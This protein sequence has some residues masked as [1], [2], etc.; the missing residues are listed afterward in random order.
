MSTSYN[1]SEPKFFTYKCTKA[2][3]RITRTSVATMP[4][5]GQHSFSMRFYRRQLKRR[6][7]KGRIFNSAMPETEFLIQC[8][9]FLKYPLN[10]NPNFSWGNPVMM[11]GYTKKS[12]GSNVVKV[13]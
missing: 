7:R 10:D 13:K 3:Y 11:V 8:L 6:T 12:S 1:L 2:L 4:C 5:I 9:L